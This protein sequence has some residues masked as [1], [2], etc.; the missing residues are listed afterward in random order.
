M[1]VGASTGGGGAAI[2]RR[3]HRAAATSRCNGLRLLPLGNRILS[4]YCARCDGESERIL[5]QTARVLIRPRLRRIC[6]PRDEDG[7]DRKGKKCEG[8]GG[9][10][11]G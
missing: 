11:M 4:V 3:V 2:V 9:H 8:G 7:W 10:E 6:S 5:L 1:V